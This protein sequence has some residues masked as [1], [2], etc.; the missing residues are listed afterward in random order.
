MAYIVE[1]LDGNGDVTAWLGPH[2]DVR[3][4]RWEAHVYPDQHRAA[5]DV[6]LFNAPHPPDDLT[7]RVAEVV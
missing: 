4:C 1:I 6:Y 5:I 7:A 3:S 2:R